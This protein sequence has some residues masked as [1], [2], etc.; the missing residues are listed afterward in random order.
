MSRRIRRLGGGAITAGALALGL[1]VAPA[2]HADVTPDQAL[3]LQRQ[4]HDWLATVLGP[5]VDLPVPA[6]RIVADGEQYRVEIP[7][8]GMIS[9]GPGSDGQGSIADAAPLTA[10][11]K[12]L[13]GGRWA[14]DDLRIPSPLRIDMAAGQAGVS[15][16]LSMK[17]ADQQMHAVFDPTLATPSSFDGRMR[18]FSQ[19]LNSSVGRQRSSSQTTSVERLTWHQAWQPEAGGHMTLLGE[20]TL[21]GYATSRQ[22]PNGQ[23][24]TIAID[25]IHATE[26]V[27]QAD[28]DEFG[29]TL[30]AALALAAV[31][32]HE[33]IPATAAAGEPP[34][35]DMTPAQRAALRSLVTDLGGLAAG[36]ESEQTMQ[37]VHIR[38]AGHVASI[39][40]VA[41]SAG[42][43]APNG[44]ADLHLRL[45]IDGIDSPDIPPGVWRDYLPRHIVFAP[46][47]S[48]IP[49]DELMRVLLRT[50]DT[51]ANH[52]PVAPSPMRMAAALLA[53]APLMLGIDTLSVDFGPARLT[54]TGDLQMVSPADISGEAELRM[55]GLDQLLQAATGTPALR[56]AGPVL[57]FLKGIGKVDGNATVW[58]I[59]YRNGEMMV[60]GTDIS[61]MVPHQ[62]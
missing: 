62:K 20:T 37:G 33:R 7:L 36:M 31:V 3:A 58:K 42:F 55:T 54:G 50:I 59:I 4:V 12:P 38:A 41:L 34:P 11:V 5:M 8:P 30:R 24:L 21:D 13:A 52:G 46:R 6:L 53:K 43:G 9:D 32:P 40:D 2:A 48:G 57:I 51:Q 49:K 14:I 39:A 29:K 44:K 60:N 25:R 47:L 22:M 61:A 17:I 28:F 23:D 45:A 56:R 16:S 18:G 15:G 35:S 1:L 27:N 10:E 26:R 19:T